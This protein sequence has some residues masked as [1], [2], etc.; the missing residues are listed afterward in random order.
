MNRLYTLLILLAMLLF[1][2]VAVFAY[3][4]LDVIDARLLRALPTAREF[5]TRPGQEVTYSIRLMRA[6]LTIWST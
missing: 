4:V 2:P 1:H 5:F 6:T 3:P